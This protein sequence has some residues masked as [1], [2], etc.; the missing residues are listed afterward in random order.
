MVT[1]ITVM[2]SDREGCDASAPLFNSRS[3]VP[4]HDEKAAIRYRENVHISIWC[5]VLCSEAANRKRKHAV[6]LAA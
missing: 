3:L 5:D 2:Q 6:V 4:T 1:G